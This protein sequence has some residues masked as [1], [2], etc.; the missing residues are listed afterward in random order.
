M[1]KTMEVGTCRDI[2]LEGEPGPDGKQHCLAL[3]E[4]DTTLDMTGTLWRVF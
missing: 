3:E 1:G 4:S 2:T